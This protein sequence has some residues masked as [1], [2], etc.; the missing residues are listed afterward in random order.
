[1]PER[2]LQETQGLRKEVRDLRVELHNSKG[3]VRRLRILTVLIILIFGL[4]GLYVVTKADDNH[5][6]AVVQ[7]ENANE[8]REFQYR[9]WLF[10]LGQELTDT[11][12]QQN[13][14]EAEMAER[15]LPIMKKGWR[16]RDCDNLDTPYEIE[17]PPTPSGTPPHLLWETQ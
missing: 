2:L 13:N 7:C 15:I 3:V 11:G 1:M 14:V 4:F 5:D 12:S 8:S 17:M 9:A 16:P 6:N 10:V